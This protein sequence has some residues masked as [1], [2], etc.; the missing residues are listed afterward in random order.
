MSMTV[1]AGGSPDIVQLLMM[2]KAMSA[3]QTHN[4]QLLAALPQPSPVSP[5]PPPAAGTFYL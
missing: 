2:R 3:E 5:A 1:S 4:E